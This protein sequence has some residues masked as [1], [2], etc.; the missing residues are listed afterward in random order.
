MNSMASMSRGWTEDQ[1]RTAL[2]ISAMAT[3]ALAIA[4]ICAERFHAGIFESIGA[5]AA[6]IHAS[7]S[8]VYA[9]AMPCPA[10][11]ITAHSIRFRMRHITDC[12]FPGMRQWSVGIRLA[13]GCRLGARI[14]LA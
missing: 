14:T 6:S 2:G 3:I 7:W 11:R 13:K 10:G 1:L 4:I 8:H 5:A 12:Y 9:P